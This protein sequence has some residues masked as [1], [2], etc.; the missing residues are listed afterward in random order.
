M[1]S[2]DSGEIVVAEAG[3]TVVGRVAEDAVLEWACSEA[4]TASAAP[5]DKLAAFED[6]VAEAADAQVGVVEGA[7]C[8]ET[9]EAVAVADL[10]ADASAIQQ[11][12][13]DCR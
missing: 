12:P 11:L 13:V 10:V 8:T 1:A 4:A 6:A 2:E 5:V 3:E 9:A 7:E